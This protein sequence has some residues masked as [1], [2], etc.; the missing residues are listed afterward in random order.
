MRAHEFVDEKID[1]KTVSQGFTD[2]R[3]IGDLLI[4]AE[5]DEP[6]YGD[7]KA[8]A[9]RVRVLTNDKER[10]ELA[11]ADFLVR[12]R[13]EDGEEYLES[14]YTYV[15]PSERG[16][17]LAKLIYKYVNDLG[18]DI[19]PSGLQT[20]YGKG[21]WKGLSKTIKQPPPLPKPVEQ[22]KLKWWQRLAKKIS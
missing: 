2:R 11:W 15:N 7:H 13:R 16:K 14:A 21:M 6:V 8:R 17:G 3:V 1:P 20:D 9:L 22:P 4:V 12:T 19:Q 5:G 18:N 10:R